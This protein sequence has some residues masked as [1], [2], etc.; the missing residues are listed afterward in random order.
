MKEYKSSTSNWMKQNAAQQ[1]QNVKQQHMAA[2][3]PDKVQQR[4]PIHGSPL[5][6]KDKR[7]DSRQ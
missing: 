1:A 5:N 3:S 7:R 4:R 6:I 2:E